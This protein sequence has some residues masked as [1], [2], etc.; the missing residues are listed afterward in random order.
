MNAMPALDGFTPWP[1]ELADHY[2][3]AG[4]WRDETLGGLLRTWAARSGDAPAV[5]AENVGS[6]RRL[7]YAE[8]DGRVDATAAGLRALGIAARDRVV[9]HLPNTLDFVVVFFALLRCGAVPVLALPAHR[10]SEIEHFVTLS[11][12]VAYVVPDEHEGF[13][14]RGLAAD[15]A[16]KAPSLRHV[17]VSGDPG[18]FTALDALP[19]GS[20]EPLPEADPGDVAVLL[21]SG[22]TTGKPKLIPRTHRDYAYN[23]RASAEV[24]ALTSDD[25]YLASLPVAHNFPLACPG[26]LGVL[27]AGGT[28]VLSPSPSPDVG[29]RLVER[30]RVTVT[31]LVPPMVRMWVDVAAWDTHD[32]SS[33]RL[34]QVGGA[35][36]DDG[37]ARQVTPALGCRLQQVFGM[38][39]GLLNYTRLDDPD[40]LVF[41][42]QGRPLSPDDEVRVVD[43][44]GDPVAP[45][46]VG[47]LWTRGPYTLRGYYRVPEYNATSFTPDGFYRSGDLVRQLPSG[48]LVVEGRRKDV[49]N[50]G[51]ENVSAATLEE[52]LL[53]H[54]AIAQVA[55]LGL[56][57][58][59]VGER[60]CAVVV[61][62]PDAGRAP[63]LKELRA[64]L[65]D[66]GLARFMYPDRLVVRDALPLTG[67]GKINKRELVAGLTAGS[68]EKEGDVS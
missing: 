67:V 62:A 47:E 30:H 1:G 33:L 34:L 52:H 59:S 37:L 16:A 65:I 15:V 23:A 58:D 18:P 9:V 19:A 24:C 17:L 2:R 49:I 64:F 32:R 31:A 60:V 53:A 54:P 48:H 40:E 26:L 38:A 46:E 57:D 29:L 14:F 3:N 27:G 25:V 36:L 13:D 43:E 7:S 20:A 63:K 35:K 68:Q 28:V 12:A 56:P 39:E 21:I 55:V 8:L 11:E 42:T 4:H 44:N 22:G 66:R 41:G 50:R 61:L 6:A 45:G 5:V 51:G 10:Q